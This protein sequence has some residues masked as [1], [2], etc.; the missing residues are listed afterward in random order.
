MIARLAGGLVLCLGL[1][2][3]VGHAQVFLALPDLPR[4]GSV[5]LGGGLLRN[6]GFDVESLPAELTGNA[7]NEAQPVTLFRT[8]TRV[9]G[10]S[11][12]SV[13]AG[14]FL[15]P[16]VSV[17]AGVTYSRPV[18]SV[19][20]FDDFEEAAPITVEQTMSRYVFD[21]SLLLH[22]RRWAFAGGRG[23]PFVIAGA[24]YLRELH[25]GRELVET[26][27]TYHAGAGVKYWMTQGRRRLGLRGDALV[28]IRDGAYGSDTTR[29]AHPSLGATLTYLF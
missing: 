14:V 10:V 4:R 3:G 12:A 2:G 1:S 26:G 20:V 15:T 13:R 18:V 9:G 24:G 16:R 6:G 21:G 25:E 23:A 8:E 22:P 19:R 28:V 11:G 29:R 7:G 27:R 5:E 17:E